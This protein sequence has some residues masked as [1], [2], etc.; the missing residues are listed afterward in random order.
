MH[1]PAAFDLSRFRPG[2][3]DAITDVAGVGV[4]HA[5]VLRGEGA[6]SVG[7]GPVRTG[8]TVVV[9]HDGD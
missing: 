1:L 3:H 6:L 9:P 7:E 2:E 8:V 5:T 4:G